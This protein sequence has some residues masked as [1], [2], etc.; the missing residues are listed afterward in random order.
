MKQVSFKNKKIFYRV[1]G[2]GKPVVL[3]HGFAEDGSLWNYQIEK[4]KQNFQVIIPD[5]PGSGAS[6]MIEGKLSISDYADAIKSIVDVEIRK[7][8]IA[9]TIIG[10]SMGGYIS[11]A[12]A[13]KY[14]ELLNGIGL[15]HSTS[16]ADDDQKK[17]AR[18]KG[19]DF[20]KKNG[21]ETFLKNT[22]QNLFSETTK[23]ENPALPK[24]LITLSK[25]LTPDVLIQ[26]YEAIR[27]RPDRSSILKYFAKPVLFIQGFYDNATPLQSGLEQSH[28]APVTYFK[29]LKDSGHVGRR[30]KLN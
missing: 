5:L 30:I 25:N 14:L 4:L 6:E 29:I 24:K 9:F 7:D 10:H 22:A 3:L 28:M 2:K 18:N 17:E 19:I 20:I 26:Y 15:F 8:A 21:A 23:K 11:L 27:D 13:E 16:F 12:F 1:V